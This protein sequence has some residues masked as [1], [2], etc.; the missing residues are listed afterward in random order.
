VGKRLSH[1]NLHLQHALTIDTCLTAVS[2]H[3]SVVYEC[4]PSEHSLRN[5]ASQTEIRLLITEIRYKR[6]AIQGLKSTILYTLESLDIRILEDRKNKFIA[7]PQIL[8]AALHPLPAS[9]P[10]TL[11][12]L[13]TVDAFIVAYIHFSCA[14]SPLVLHAG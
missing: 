3:H 11:F 7:R 13:Y 2:L 6:R 10:R 14:S 5:N 9:N 4:L 1:N 8:V 12:N